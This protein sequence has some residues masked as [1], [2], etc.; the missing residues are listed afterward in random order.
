MPYKLTK[1]KKGWKVCKKRAKKCFSKSPLSKQKAI[2]Q[3]AALYINEKN[4]M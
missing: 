4:K 2:K 3:I 1:T